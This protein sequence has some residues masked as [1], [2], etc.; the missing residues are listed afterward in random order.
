MRRRF[1][2]AETGAMAIFIALTTCFVVIPLGALAVDLGTQ[3]ISRV[4]AQ[5]VADTTALD[6]AR[7]LTTGGAAAVTNAAAT[8]DANR[9]AGSVGS[10]MTVLAYT[11]TLSSTFVSD[12]SLG[13]NGSTS[14]SYFTPTTTNPTAVLVVVKNSV[15][16]AIQG[17]SG[18]VCRSSIAS[19]VSAQKACVTM[20]SY[21]AALNTGDSSVLGILNKA[22]GTNISS[23]V[24]S[25]SGILTAGVNVLDFLNV[26]KTNLALGSADQVLAANV[27]AAQINAAMI[28]VLNNNGQT[29]SANLLQTIG[30]TINSSTQITVGTLLGLSSGT[31]SA[32]ET[33]INPLDLITAAA[34]LANGSTAL[35][36]NIASPPGALT[37][38]TAGISVGSSPTTFCLGQGTVTMGQTSINATVNFN[39]PGTLTSA[40][41]S[42]LNGLTGLLSGV[43]QG[44]GGLLGGDTY[45][46]NSVTLGPVTAKISLASASGKVTGL[47]CS[48][49]TPTGV[50]VQ[51][52]SSL[53][54]ATIT[55]P[56]SVSATHGYAGLLGI[57]RQTENATAQYLL[58]VTTD[59]SGKTVAATLS[60]PGAYTTPQ[61]GPS[62][63]L[64][65]QY[66]NITIPNI[67]PGTFAHGTAGA[68]TGQKSVDGLFGLST[69]TTVLTQVQNTILSPLETLVMTPLFNTLTS[70]LQSTV[71]TTI[72]GSTYLAQSA[73]CIVPKLVG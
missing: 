32:L 26:L 59:S 34:Q 47:T 30:A 37:G 8:A 38:F 35:S 48:G 20:D 22:L 5:A 66:T 7:L 72:A 61:Q 10:G 64:S 14:N 12:Q 21:A 54:P 65:L 49:G 19:S 36:V 11:G 1:Q 46:L 18:G 53:L 69:V 23:Q 13:C 40:V 51:E 63:N 62:N 71:G 43:L 4:D 45:T 67:N 24:L 41:T 28:K 31:G 52:G 9:T 50:N 42:L 73:S 57:G 3:R 60:L 2:R 6:M 44:L 29:A 58:T 68:S 27:T 15:N 33:N 16:F 55:I 70:T 39:Q 17:G 25:S 56:I